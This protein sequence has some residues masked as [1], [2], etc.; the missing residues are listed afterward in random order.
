MFPI[1]LISF[2]A[3][4]SRKVYKIQAEKRKLFLCGVHFMFS[5]IIIIQRDLFVAKLNLRYIRYCTEITAQMWYQA[6]RLFLT[7]IVQYLQKE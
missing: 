3:I 2:S 7:Q 5:D 4:Q 1:L 6:F